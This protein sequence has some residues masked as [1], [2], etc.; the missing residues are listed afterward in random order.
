MS[1]TGEVSTPSGLTS[2]VQLGKRC[3][4]NPTRLGVSERP[5]ERTVLLQGKGPLQKVGG[6][7]NGAR[8]IPQSAKE[9]LEQ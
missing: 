1:K 9:A 8:G 5:E 3:F 2:R 4:P 6:K 7:Y